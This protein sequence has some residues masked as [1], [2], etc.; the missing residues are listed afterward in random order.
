LV[1]PNIEHAEMV[2]AKRITDAKRAKLAAAAPKP[3]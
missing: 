3:V 1:G 2:A